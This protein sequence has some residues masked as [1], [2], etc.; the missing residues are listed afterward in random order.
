MESEQV[1]EFNEAVINV[2]GLTVAPGTPI[3][4]GASNKKHMAESHKSDF[5]KYGARLGR[6]I[7]EPDYVGLHNDGS[8]EYV[9]SW[10][11]YVKVAVRVAGDGEYYART[12]YH[13]E[14]K[15]AEEL[16]AQGRW[17]PLTK[18]SP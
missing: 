11:R 3:Y 2:L 7:K 17:K 6:I 12:L 18:I 9:K 5:K 15:H 13:V 14:T 10:G 1:G 16:V 4:L 8:V